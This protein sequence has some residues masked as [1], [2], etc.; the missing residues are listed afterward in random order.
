MVMHRVGRQAAYYLHAPT[1]LGLSFS[2]SFLFSTS[3]IFSD[4][5][6]IFTCMSKVED[7]LS[8]YIIADQIPKTA[9]VTVPAARVCLLVSRR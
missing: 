5:V 9:Q 7:M 4:T 6:Q 8:V 3:P 2:C 1:K